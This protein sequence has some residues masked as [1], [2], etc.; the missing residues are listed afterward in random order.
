MQ[1]HFPG[2]NKQSR[3]NL[4][5]YTRNVAYAQKTVSVEN[6]QKRNRHITMAG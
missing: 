4:S 2:E 5:H 3:V 1:R 6:A